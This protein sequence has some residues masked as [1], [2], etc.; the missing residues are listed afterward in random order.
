MIYDMIFIYCNWVSTW[1]QWSV[2]LYK[3]RKET[4]IYKRGNITQNNTKAQIHKIE[5]KRTKQENNHKKNIK[6]TLVECQ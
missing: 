1:W 5:N 6:I 4:A 2:N 3:N